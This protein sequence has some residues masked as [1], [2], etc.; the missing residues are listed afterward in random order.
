MTEA[1]L[2]RWHRTNPD[3]YHRETQIAADVC[4][5]CDREAAERESAS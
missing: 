3:A 4:L 1:D 5:L 2:D